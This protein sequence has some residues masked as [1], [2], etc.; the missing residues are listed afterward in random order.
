MF[1]AS[2]I[3]ERNRLSDPHPLSWRERYENSIPFFLPPCLFRKEDN[4][5]LAPYHREIVSQPQE[6]FFSPQHGNFVLP[7]LSF[8]EAFSVVEEAT[9]SVL[10]TGPF[11]AAGRAG[12]GSPPSPLFPS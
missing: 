9:S 4:L 12:N 11:S 7:F 1:D 8:I 2:N 6:S 3:R 10:T 5:V